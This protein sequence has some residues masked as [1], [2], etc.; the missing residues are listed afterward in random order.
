MAAT[1]TEG[2]TESSSQNWSEFISN[3][4]QYFSK[5]FEIE[6]SVP[7][8]VSKESKE[9]KMAARKLR[10]E[11]QKIARSEKLAQE[12]VARKNFMKTK[13]EA[14]DLLVGINFNYTKKFSKST[15]HN[16]SEKQNYTKTTLQRLDIE[17]SRTQTN[18][19][20]LNCFLPKIND[21]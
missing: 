7:K 6:K 19:V 15:T 11:E 2:F 16:F 20:T 17:P 8:N 13:K 9:S 18:S 14:E 1:S 4:A 5:Q 3:T 10:L 12:R 21:E